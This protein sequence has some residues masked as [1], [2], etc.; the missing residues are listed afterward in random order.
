MFSFLNELNT[1]TKELTQ[2]PSV[3]KMLQL[4]RDR[5]RWVVGLFTG[6]CH[7]KGHLF[8]LGLTDDPTC[9]QCLGKDES[10]THIICDGGAIAYLR[11]SH[12]VQFL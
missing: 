11:F 6:H 9:E 5:L 2:G 8:K 3:R 1:S 4:N 12:L 7:L 10:P